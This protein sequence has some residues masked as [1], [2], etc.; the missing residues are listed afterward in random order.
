MHQWSEKSS[1]FSILLQM[2]GSNSQC[3]IT[4]WQGSLGA[5]L[6]VFPSSQIFPSKMAANFKENFITPK[7]IE[8]VYRCEK[9]IFRNDTDVF[10]HSIIYIY[11]DFR[12]LFEQHAMYHKLAVFRL[13]LSLCM[14]RC[15]YHSKVGEFNGNLFRRF[16]YFHDQIDDDTRSSLL[17]S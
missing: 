1:N 5:R 6:D 14:Y 4:L 13:I 9:I 16:N 3:N 8:V 11:Y 7:F 15:M 10:I 12:S 2:Q 17:S